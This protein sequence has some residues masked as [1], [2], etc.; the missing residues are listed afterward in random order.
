MEPRRIAG[1]V[2]VL[3]VVAGGF[4]WWSRPRESPVV[5]VRLPATFSPLAA[6]G[7]EVF[8]ANCAACHGENAGGSDLGPPLVHP[9]Y[10]PAH[11][12]DVAIASAIRFGVRQHHWYY[13][14]MPPR[15]EVD[16]ADIP[17]VVAYIRE[18]QRE[19]GIR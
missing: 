8:A 9:I 6:R 16:D 17:A 1:M 18:L 2:A 3:A 5:E 11:H 15:P 10:R 4:W 13:G 12:A 19:N 14:D 7:R